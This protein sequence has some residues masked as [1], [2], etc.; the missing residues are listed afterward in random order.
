MKVK[1]FEANDRVGG[2]IFTHKFS[3]EPYQYCEAGAMR[4]P[5]PTDNPSP[6]IQLVKYLNKSGSGCCLK[7]ID[8][9]NSCPS[10][11][12]VFV[13][14]TTMKDG[15]V[16][17]VE[18]ANA[19][20]SELGF[21][22]IED[23]DQIHKLFMEALKPVLLEQE[24]N[25]D[26]AVAKWNYG[27]MLSL[28]NASRY[29]VIDAATMFGI[30]MSSDHRWST[31][32][33]GMSK[34][35]EECAN[36]VCRLG[37]DIILNTKVE[38]VEYDNDN[39]SVK[40]GVKKKSSNCIDFETFSSVIFATPTSCLLSLRRPQWPDDMERA[41]HSLQYW[42]SMK[43]SLRFK[44]RF[45]ESSSLMH[46]PSFGGTSVTDLSISRIF[47]PSYGIGRP[48]KGILIAYILEKDA[49][50][51]RTLSDSEKVQV[52]LCDLQKLYPDVN[53]A[54]EYEGGTD[55]GNEKF[56]KETLIMDWTSSGPRELCPC[57]LRV[58]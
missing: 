44:S 26:N 32:D 20:C 28:T 11:N 41:I 22:N 5:N 47:Y 16:M 45:W 50:H 38:S 36:V 3:D 17:T 18:Y 49:V 33:G 29:G 30:V 27:T 8:F 40:L 52:F 7:L 57:I 51:L 31:I 54:K 10:G 56:L 12:R 43:I 1:L 58:S 19:H 35:P 42:P 13:N 4:I 6:V 9:V 2:R 55:I 25:F 21:R 24:F 53:I 34:L 39:D 23:D 46:A 48:G 37:G 15:R 14:G